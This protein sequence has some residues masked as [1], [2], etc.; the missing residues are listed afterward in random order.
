MISMNYTA[1]L[2]EVFS[3]GLY[4]A[5]FMLNDSESIKKD[6][7]MLGGEI[8]GALYWSPAPDIS[9]NLG[10]GAFLASLGNIVPDEKTYWRVELN[11]VLSLF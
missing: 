9:I 1:R 2:H 8:F 5:Y 11:I 6:K 4:P 3:V 7:R 10:G